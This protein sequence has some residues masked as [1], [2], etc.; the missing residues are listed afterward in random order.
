METITVKVT[1]H[2]LNPEISILHVQGIIYATTLPQVHKAFQE[3]LKNNKKKIIFDLSGTTYISSG[4]WG[5]FIACHQAALEKDAV[6]ALTGMKLEVFDAFELLEYD[7]VLA[8]FTT[9]E[10]ALKQGFGKISG[11]VN[12]SNIALA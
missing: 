8:F 10:D 4:G 7:K 12:S 6:I 9:T 5:L 3:I 1:N 11:L 2:A